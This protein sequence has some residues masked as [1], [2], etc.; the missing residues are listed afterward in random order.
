MK[1]CDY[2]GHENTD[3]AAHCPGCGTRFTLEDDPQPFKSLERVA[4]ERKIFSGGFSVCIGA[5]L[6]ALLSF[7]SVVPTLFGIAYCMVGTGAVLFGGLRI[8]RGWADRD[9]QR[10]TEEIGREA[11]SYAAKLEAE[12]QIQEALLVY[13]EIIQQYPNSKPERDA[14]KSIKNLKARDG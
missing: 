5:I 13:Q 1:T 7:F 10:S 8:C 12:G 11:F 3:D 6:L 2:C 4:A 9:K 14:K